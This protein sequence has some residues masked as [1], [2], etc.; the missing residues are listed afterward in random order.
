MRVFELDNRPA[1]MAFSSNRRSPSRNP[2]RNP[3][4]PPGPVVPRAGVRVCGEQGFRARGSA[5]A[6]AAEEEEEE[7]E[8]AVAAAVKKIGVVLNRANRVPQSPAS[9]PGRC[10]KVWVGGC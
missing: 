10:Q 3:R 5:V 4:P 2:S 6:A 9:I 1:P 8:E 7:E